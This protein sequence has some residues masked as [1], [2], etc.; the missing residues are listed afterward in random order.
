[1]LEH[2]TSNFEDNSVPLYA[3]LEFIG[4]KKLNDHLQRPL[5]INHGTAIAIELRRI[6]KLCHEAGVL[7]RDI[8]LDN[9]IIKA[10]SESLWLVDF[11]LTWF[12]DDSFPKIRSVKLDIIKTSLFKA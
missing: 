10:E 9:I 2:N 6:V 8:K 12:E 5:R 1:V 7:H 11:G 4:G 3:I